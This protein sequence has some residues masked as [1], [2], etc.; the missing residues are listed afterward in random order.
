MYKLSQHLMP[1]QSHYNLTLLQG[2]PSILSLVYIN[3]PQPILIQGFGIGLLCL[4]E[5]ITG[6]F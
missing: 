4:I 5:L 6:L 1:K 2:Y 3:G